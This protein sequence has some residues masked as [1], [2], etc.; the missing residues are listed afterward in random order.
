MTGSRIWLFIFTITLLLSPFITVLGIIERNEPELILAFML[1][2]ATI[3][4]YDFI[5][6]IRRGIWKEKRK[7]S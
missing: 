2:M 7:Y 6:Q 3:L 4:S 1:G 5:M